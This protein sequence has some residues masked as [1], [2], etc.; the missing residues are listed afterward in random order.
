MCREVK[1][2]RILL[3]DDDDAVRVTIRKLLEE[4]G[5]EVDTAIDGEDG[6]AQFRQQ[7]PDLVI[8][9][10]RMPRASGRDVIEAI[11]KSNPALP[12]IVVTAYMAEALP[13]ISALGVER[14][15]FKPFDLR[16]LVDAVS[17][18]LGV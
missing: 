7:A 1:L 17:E 16:R 5:H 6:I 2:A 14:I 8:T 11:R 12:I 4:P 3:I 18:C 13:Q 10:Y 15:F 9:D